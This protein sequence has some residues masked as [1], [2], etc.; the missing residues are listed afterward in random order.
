MNAEHG[1]TSEFI[2][3]EQFLSRNFFLVFTFTLF[4]KEQKYNIWVG[5]ETL[6]LGP[7]AYVKE[8]ELTCSEGDIDGGKETLIDVT[9]LTISCLSGVFIGMRRL[10]LSGNSLPLK[11]TGTTSECWICPLDIIWN[12]E[13]PTLKNNKL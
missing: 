7:L 3:C 1:T 6:I 10:M 8:E 13:M 4:Y 9:P 2:L 11:V 12:L 5:C